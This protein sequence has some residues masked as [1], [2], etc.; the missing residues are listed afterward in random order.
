MNT[1]VGVMIEFV[2][3]EE[4]SLVFFFVKDVWMKVRVKGIWT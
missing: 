3:V 1:Q 2:R 4:F